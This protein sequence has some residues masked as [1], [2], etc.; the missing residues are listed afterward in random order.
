MKVGAGALTTVT[1][2]GTLAARLGLPGGGLVS[3]GIDLVSP[4]LRKRGDVA[5]SAVAAADVGRQGLAV[6][7]ALLAQKHPELAQQLSA[8]VAAATGGR[9]DGLEG[10]F[11]T[12]AKAYTLDH[13]GKHAEAVDSLLTKLRGEH[14]ATT[15]GIASAL[16]SI[17][18]P[19]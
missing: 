17:I 8:V 19:A 18:K 6:V 3:L 10:L 2:L 14:I 9:A 1:V 16:Q 4:M 12:C 15:G 7:E 5:E 11:K 13:S